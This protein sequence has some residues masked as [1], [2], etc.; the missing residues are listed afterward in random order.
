MK[1]LERP[2]CSIDV[3]STGTDPAVD[4][5]V[6]IGI[7]K[8]C[9]APSGEGV[10]TTY[11]QLI[12]PGQ[13][14]PPKATEVHHITDE[15]VRDMP[16]FKGVAQRVLGIMSGCDL[17][18]FNLNR[19]DVSIIWEELHRAGLHWDLT[20]TRI[21]DAGAIFMKK[22]P[23]TLT[24][25]LRIYA[26]I[27]ERIGAHDA[28]ADAMGTWDVFKGQVAAHPDIAAMSM[29]ELHA[30]SKFQDNIDLA[31][32]LVMIDGLACYGFGKNKG[33]PIYMNT[34]YADWML[35]KDF[36]ANTKM[37]LRA[38]LEK[39]AIKENEIYRERQSRQAQQ[40]EIPF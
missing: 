31:G 3:E 37:H 1:P 16:H 13:P 35:Q 10:C 8:V 25:A 38:I 5:I 32:K 12:D 2:I 27:T 18:G 9:Y 17:V 21:V 20:G 11:S 19:F 33:T 29:D 4:R 39:I 7:Y 24:D 14:I 36:S 30:F 15:M 40:P 22:Q 28:L 6:Q 26:G 23:R 34:D